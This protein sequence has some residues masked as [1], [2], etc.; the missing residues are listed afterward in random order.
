[1]S[2]ATAYQGTFCGRAEEVSRIR[3]QIASY[4]AGCPAA[5]DVVLIAGEFAANAVLHSRSRGQLIQVR[6][7][8]SP[9]S[10]RIEV[11]DMGGPWRTPRNDDRPHGLDIVRALAGHGNWGTQTTS[12]GHRIVWAT[13]QW[14][15]RTER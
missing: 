7:Q 4:L 11:Q 15:D 12:D 1:V 2:T 6:C 10:V 14:S 9:G 13:L 8:M 5:D 3:H